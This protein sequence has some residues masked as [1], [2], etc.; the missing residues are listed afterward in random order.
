MPGGATGI[1]PVTMGLQSWG[2]VR[3]HAGLREEQGEC[4]SYLTVDIFAQPASVVNTVSG[5]VPWK[6]RL[7]SGCG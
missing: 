1:S 6:I 2:A 7:P 5:N 3:P 4:E